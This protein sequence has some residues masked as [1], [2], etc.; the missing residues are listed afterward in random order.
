MDYKQLAATIL[1]KVGGKENIN[2]VTHCATRLR[3]VLKDD[4]LADTAGL[5]ETPGVKGVAQSGGQ[6][7]VIIGSDVQSVYRPL[8]EQGNLSEDAPVDENLDQSVGAKVLAAISGIFTPILPVIT[9][10]G[11][12]KAVLSLLVVFKLVTTDS[13][14]YQ[15]LNFIGDAGFYFLPAFLGGTAARQFKAN[16]YLGMLI[17]AILL[18]PT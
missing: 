5:K 8:V 13:Q 11:M 17:G 6:Y 1:T 3:F 10:A 4:S 18:H 2:S 9:A 12:I 16:P 14:S 7:Q 15:I